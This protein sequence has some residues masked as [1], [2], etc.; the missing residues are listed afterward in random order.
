MSPES[1]DH[2]GDILGVTWVFY[3]L[4]GIVVALVLAGLTVWWVV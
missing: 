3:K 2:A 4:A 1:H